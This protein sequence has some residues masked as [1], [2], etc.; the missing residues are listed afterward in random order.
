LFVLLDIHV[1]ATSLAWYR[2]WPFLF[3]MVLYKTQVIRGHCK[4]KENN[5]IDPNLYLIH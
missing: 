2:R 5:M 1:F 3:F 4:A